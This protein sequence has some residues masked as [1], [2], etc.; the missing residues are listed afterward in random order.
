MIPDLA[1]TDPALL[2]GAAVIAWIVYFAVVIRTRR[3]A[4]KR[5]NR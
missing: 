2:I 5:V 3:N 1:L 4:A